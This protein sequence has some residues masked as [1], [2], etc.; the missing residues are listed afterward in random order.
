MDGNSVN[1]ENSLDFKEFIN[2]NQK[3]Q[4]IRFNDVFLYNN[5]RMFKLKLKKKQNNNN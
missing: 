4:K 1:M 5:F 2:E 3:I